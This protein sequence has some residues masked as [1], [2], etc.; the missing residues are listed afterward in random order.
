LIFEYAAVDPQD[1]RRLLD[2][3]ASL[4][5]D[6]P[7]DLPLRQSWAQS[8]ANFLERFVANPEDQALLHELA[9]VSEAPVYTWES[10]LSLHKLENNEDS[11]S[12]AGSDSLHYS[13]ARL[14]G[15]IMD[16][17]AIDLN[18]AADELGLSKERA[19]EALKREAANASRETTRRAKAKRRLKWDKDRLP[20]ENPA[21]FAWRAYQAEAKAGTLHRGVIGQEDKLLAKK[22]ANWLRTH[23]MPEGIDI[24][25]LPEWNTRQLAKQKGGEAEL[26]RL[27]GVARRRKQKPPAAAAG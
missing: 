18:A 8:V 16:D 21:A 20:D 27:Y 14:S 9:A 7:N 2:D 4:H 5:R 3:L 15:T 22:L 23:A 17:A 11:L 12:F 1:C 13:T 19:F 24:P 25:T 6:D 10:G 26:V